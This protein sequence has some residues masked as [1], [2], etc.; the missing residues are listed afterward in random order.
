MT[1]LASVAMVLVL[2]GCA[3]RS[4]TTV[5]EVALPVEVV[6]DGSVDRETAAERRERVG[7]DRIVR[8]VGGGAIGALIGGAIA[9]QVEGD[10]ID[11]TDQSWSTKTIEGA[12][13]GAGIGAVAGWLTARE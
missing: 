6:V 4:H 3:A 5:R 12:L 10:R 7:K 9:S 2:F 1:K 8:M 11:A 13:L